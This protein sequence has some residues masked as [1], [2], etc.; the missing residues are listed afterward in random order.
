MSELCVWAPRATRVEVELPS[1]RRPLEPRARGYWALPAPELPAGTRYR[2]RLD[3]GLPLPDPRSSFQPEG[4]HGPS[5][6]VDHTSFA[7]TDAE[8]VPRP[9]SHAVI[10]ELHVG[11][12]SPA[13]TFLAAIGH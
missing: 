10:Y 4:V 2:L 12:F 8:F 3:G 7:W 11:T 1:G 6:W 13:G 5:E 9:L